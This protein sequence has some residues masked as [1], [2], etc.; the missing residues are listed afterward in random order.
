MKGTFLR[1]TIHTVA[2]VFATHLHAQ[3]IAPPAIEWQKS[4]ATSNGMWMS[5]VY[6]TPDGGYI[7]AGDC[8]SSST[9]AFWVLRLDAEGNKLWA[10]TY[11]DGHLAHKLSDFQPAH[12]GG[13][14]L[15]GISSAPAGSRDKTSPVIG[16][17][18]FWMIHIDD[19][20]NKLWDSTYGRANFNLESLW[21]QQTTD[22]GYI[23]AGT[24]MTNSSLPE[25]IWAVRLDASGNEIWN[26]VLG[27][28]SVQGIGGN[29]VK[30]ILEM[31]GGG[32]LVGGES[33]ASPSGNKTSPAYG[34]FDMWVVRLDANGAKLWD[35]SFGGSGTEYI[36]TLTATPDGGF[37]AGGSSSSGISGNKTTPYY[38][39][40]SLGDWWLVRGDSNGTMLWNK[41]FG[42]SQ[43]DVLKNVEQT[44]D[45][46]FVL[47]GYSSSTDGNK[48]SANYGYSDY[49]VA[50]MDRNGNE[51]WQQSYGSTTGD[52]LYFL[53][54]TRDG[55]FFLAGLSGGGVSG[56]K[57]APLLGTLDMWLV[58]LGS[59][60]MSAPP[61]IRLQA[62]SPAQFQTNGSRL[63]LNGVSNQLY[64][65][66][67]S[68]N[69]LN[70]NP[71]QT[72]RVAEAELELTDLSATNDA[73]RFY[74]AVPMPE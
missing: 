40:Y 33:S 25:Y 47:C 24:F 57:T 43:E 37:L 54:Q 61:R 68:T 29:H 20:G 18:D 2:I 13:W 28:S 21:F 53:K 4:Y 46:G 71:L 72:N 63:S 8:G 50:R 27:G 15:G 55:G 48:T 65:L 73:R 59:D 14:V 66:E 3:T 34:G 23:L 60:A 49:W 6:Q 38:G 45:G 7:I 39:G 44:A 11:G 41:S 51:L 17:S 22:S 52:A 9:D 26:T 30:K 32:F 19:N 10:S 58:K 5:G 70:W 56:N 67:Y 62:Q 42:G 74:R 12:D 16:V 69:L 36:T 64:R 1:F 35:S 31:P